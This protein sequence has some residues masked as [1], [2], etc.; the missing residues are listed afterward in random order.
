MALFTH[1]PHSTAE[2]VARTL[3]P[4]TARGEL[5]GLVAHRDARVR[6]ALAAN[7]SSPLWVVETLATDSRARIRD[8]ALARLRA[9]GSAG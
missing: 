9:L 3:D 1:S 4:R 5:V 7:P 2:E 8:R 6:E